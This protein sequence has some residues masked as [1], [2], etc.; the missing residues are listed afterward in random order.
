MRNLTGDEGHQSTLLVIVHR[1][2]DAG[3]PAQRRMPAIGGDGQLCLQYQAIIQPDAHT[4]IQL[5]QLL[6]PR[7]AVHAHACAR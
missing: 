4:C 2:F 3:E 6:H 7:R 5:L 1:G